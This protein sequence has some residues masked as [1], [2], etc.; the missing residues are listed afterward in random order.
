MVKIVGDNMDT[1]IKESMII[2]GDLVPINE[3]EKNF[4]SGSIES[5]IDEEIMEFFKMSKYRICNLEAPL[6]KE[7]KYISKCGPNLKINP[8]CI[9]GLKKLKIDMVT[10]ANNHILDY[11]EKGL[12]DTIELLD[13]NRIAYCGAGKDLLESEKPL[14]FIIGGKKVGIFCCAESEFSIATEESAG[15]Y[16]FDPLYTLDVIS[17]IKKQCD[18]LIILHHGGKEFY[19]YPSPE[20]VKT[21]TRMVDKGANLVICQHSHCIGC[22]MDYKSAKI[23]YGQGN[24]LFNRKHDEFWDSG[25]IVKISFNDNDT[26]VETVPIINKLGKIQLAKGNVAKKILSDYQKRSSQIENSKFIYKNFVEFAKS[27]KCEYYKAFLGGNTLGAY[28][29][30]ALNRILPFRKN[31]DIFFKAE[32]KKEIYNYILCEAQREVLLA[33]L[34]DEE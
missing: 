2:V 9:V 8:D 30:R 1:Q 17:D 24:F 21:C 19:R 12:K 18:Y 16:G 34:N 6:T 4:I 3:D 5:N 13:R 7:D 23:I 20:L 22:E 10:L 31:E 33:I 15:A 14:F 29:Y 32:V 25:L 27:K 26:V 28:V 11:G